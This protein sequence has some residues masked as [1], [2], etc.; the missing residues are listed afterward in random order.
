MHG[1]TASS[2]NNGRV[3][4]QGNEANGS[5]VLVAGNVSAGDEFLYW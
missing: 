4:I 2:A 1:A 3:E 5:V